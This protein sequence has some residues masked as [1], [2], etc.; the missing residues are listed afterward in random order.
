M[1]TIDKRTWLLILAS[2]AFWSWYDVA[3]LNSPAPDSALSA[4]TL[5]AL[6]SFTNLIFLGVAV[7]RPGTAQ[8]LAADNR[9]VG[10]VGAAGA[11]AT[12]AMALGY[13]LGSTVLSMVGFLFAGLVS[14]CLIT[15]IAFTVGARGSRTVGCIVAASFIIEALVSGAILALDP[16]PHLVLA[17]ALPL[18]GAV[19]FIVFNRNNNASRLSASEQG[20]LVQQRLIGGIGG[21]LLLALALY[22]FGCGYFEHWFTT[23]HQAAEGALG[24]SLLYARGGAAAL[25]LMASVVLKWKQQNILRLGLMI[26][27]AGSMATPLAFQLEDASGLVGVIF[28]T[29]YTLFDIMSWVLLANIAAYRRVAPVR[30]IG[31]GMLVSSVVM[32][33]GTL[34]AQGIDS[35]SAGHIVLSVSATLVSY[36]LVMGALLAL[37]DLSR[38]WNA[39]ADEALDAREQEAREVH[40]LAHRYHLTAREEDVLLELLTDDSIPAIAERLVVSKNTMNTHV[41]RIY[42]KFDVHSRTELTQLV[43]EW[44]A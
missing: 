12:V 16:L 9:F 23:S 6:F 15:Q 13:S 41:K 22:W 29:G 26:A 3:T 43:R 20:P 17:T 19:L 10:A 27:V 5:F 39:G 37:T 31:L 44:L 7:G 8:R 2:G 24:A 35:A 11:A 33:A 36:G 1:P 4:S 38:I 14:G 34:M 32:G 21:V 30:T 42:T 25:F 40:D 28:M 18:V